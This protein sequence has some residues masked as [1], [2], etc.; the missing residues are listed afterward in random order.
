VDKNKMIDTTPPAV[1]KV[2]INIAKYRIL[3][4][5]HGSKVLVHPDTLEKDYYFKYIKH[6]TLDH[7]YLLDYYETALE[8]LTNHNLIKMSMNEKTLKFGYGMTFK[9][10]WDYHRFM[11]Y[12]L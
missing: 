7:I 4:Y 5:L 12:S 2:N 1:R 8:I 11:N 3:A 10:V 9:G 6:S